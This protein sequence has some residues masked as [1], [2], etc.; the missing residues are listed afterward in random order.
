MTLHFI[1]PYWLLLLVPLS[2]G[3]AALFFSRAQSTR[4]HK[5][6][7]VHLIEPLLMTRGR[8]KK[9]FL[10][11]LFAFASVLSVFALAGP[12]FQHVQL[13]VYQSASATMMVMDL[14]PSML[15]EDIKPNR[16]TRAKFKILDFLKRS[17]EGQVGFVAFSEYA[18]TVTPLTQDPDTLAAM[19]PELSPKIMPKHG[20]NIAAGLEKGL[21]LLNSGNAKLGTVLLI[22]DS[23]PSEKAFQIARQIRKQGFHLDVYAIGEKEGAPIPIG[24]QYLQDEMGQTVIARLP[25]DE[26][27][28]LATR[29]GGRYISFQNDNS[30]IN[31]LVQ[32]T[33][34]QDVRKNKPSKKRTQRWRDEGLWL[35]WLL[36]PFALLAFRR[37]WFEVIA[38]D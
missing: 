22:T 1:R 18:F 23:R 35:V 16:I 8:Q 10:L 3:L 32:L 34:Q 24:G 30:D 38:N 37:G 14:S 25:A 36:L 6:C 5:V 19:V 13:P 31:K 15:A 4:W 26:L 21:A 28:A 12:S 9:N 11:F 27:R 7:D 29:G 17:Q 20:N 33:H 2:F